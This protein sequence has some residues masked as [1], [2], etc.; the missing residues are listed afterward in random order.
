MSRTVRSILSAVRHGVRLV[1]Q[2]AL[3]LMRVDRTRVHEV[4][5]T[6][7]EVRADR[8]GETVTYVVNKNVNWSN[9][10][11]NG[12]LF[13]GYSRPL[14]HRDAFCFSIEDIIESIEGSLA[15]G[16]SEVCL[17]AGLHPEKTWEDY[18][19]L[20]AAVHETFPTIHIHGVTPEELKHALRNTGLSFKDGYC[21]LAE[22]G[23][24]S[25]PGTAAE[26]LVD[27]VRAKICPRKLSTREWIEAIR[28][29]NNAGLRVT[30]T[31]M[32]GHVESI[33]DRVEH[34]SILRSL[35]DETGVFTEF[36]PLPFIRY[37]TPLYE[38][39]V[40]S[41]GPNAF[42]DLLVIA[43][44]RLFLDNFT[45][46]QA[47]WV[48]YGER[49]AQVM[50]CYGANDLGGTLFG[51]SISRAAGGSNRQWL[52]VTEL[53]GLIEGIGRPP[54]ERTTLYSQVAPPAVAER[55]SSLVP[56]KRAS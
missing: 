13:C 32:Y 24:G 31:M 19:Y 35:Q 33:E 41:T 20:V 49:L 22:Q 42:E 55:S 56:W 17:V 26:I 14:D 29:A 7:D 6:A 36:I 1:E 27:P 34:L 15:D 43:V 28:G 11:T 30:A 37:N 40:V 16:I 54:R 8:A 23:L 51:E 4:L 50:L 46:I 25:V 38:Q 21:L 53:R 12:C 10:C 44:S 47:S 39:G 45:N 2:D 52:G 48:K 18:L 3:A 9:V 5:L